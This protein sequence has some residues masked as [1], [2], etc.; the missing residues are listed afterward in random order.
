MA[1]SAFFLA[2]PPSRERMVMNKFSA[3]QIIDQ[4]KER[5]E[6]TL[7]RSRHQARHDHDG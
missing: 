4:P 7:D 1:Y 5:T 3:S 2:Y 6:A